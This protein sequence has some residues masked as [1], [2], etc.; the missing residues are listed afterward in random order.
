M[1]TIFPALGIGDRVR[2]WSYAA[3]AFCLG[4]VESFVPD[5]GGRYVVVLY[6]DGTRGQ[7]EFKNLC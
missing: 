5:T 3:Y 4:T 2:V 6:D 1:I 7:V